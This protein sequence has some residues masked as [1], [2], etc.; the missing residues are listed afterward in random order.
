V[1]EHEDDIIA[2]GAQIIWVLEQDVQARAGTA[3]SCRSELDSLG[4]DAGWCVGDSETDPD[5]GAFDES[6]FSIARGF[7]M[8]VP[9]TTMVIEYTTNHGTTSGNENLD[10]AAVLAKVREIVAQQ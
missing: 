7:D 8:I 9:R 5:P 1:A 3:S 6:P 4:S 2:A 10:G